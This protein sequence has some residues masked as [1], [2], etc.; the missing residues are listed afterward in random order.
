MLQSYQQY[1]AVLCNAGSLFSY[2]AWDCAMLLRMLTL[3][4]AEALLQGWASTLQRLL[5]ALLQTSTLRAA[6]ALTTRLHKTHALRGESWSKGYYSI[7][8]RQESSHVWNTYRKC[9]V[10]A[11]SSC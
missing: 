8:V 7:Q 10:Q 9:K 3:N 2:T 11:R 1:H 4:A 5:N 6:Y